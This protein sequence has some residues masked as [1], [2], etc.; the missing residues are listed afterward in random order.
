MEAIVEGACAECTGGGNTAIGH[1][2]L[3]SATDGYFDTGIGYQALT[4]ASTGY[5]NTGVGAR[6]LLGNLDGL[7]NTAI[8]ADALSSNDSGSNNVA[9]GARALHNN[10]ASG[11]VAIGE[12]ALQNNSTGASN[13]AVGNQ[14]GISANNPSNSIFIGNSGSASDTNVIRIGTLGTQTKTVMA[15]IF[16]IAISNGSTVMMNSTGQFGTVNSSR[17]YKENI[18]SM[19]H[20]SAML[21][22]LRPVTFQYKQAYEDGSRPVEYG[23]IAEEVAEVFPYLAVFNDKG[24]PETVKYHL[25]PTFL[26]EGFQEQQRV[27]AELQARKRAAAGDHR[28][29]GERACRAA[30]ERGRRACRRSRRR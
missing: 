21:A 3:Q 13:I 6:A 17:R 30:R 7:Y 29:S 10:E 4:N 20:M 9:V 11:N 2:A 12:Q 18:R 25:L 16:G 26:L 19:G 1:S 22:R 28:C 23:L 14:A 15:G 27:I 5:Y 24:Q 8:G